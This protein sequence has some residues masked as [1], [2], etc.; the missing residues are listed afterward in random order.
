M[1]YWARLPRR[2]V[3][4]NG[5]LDGETRVQNIVWV[6][7]GFLFR[8]NGSSSVPLFVLLDAIYENTVYERTQY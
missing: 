6:W 2:L 5:R 4:E 8:K 7:K 1:A 3:V